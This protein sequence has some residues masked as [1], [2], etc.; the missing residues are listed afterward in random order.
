ME[1]YITRISSKKFQNYPYPIKLL[2]TGC[3]RMMNM[4]SKQVVDQT[5]IPGPYYYMRL[6][7]TLSLVPHQNT[8]TYRIS[9]FLFL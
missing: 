8:I 7:H 5:T 1:F 2:A 4:R 6:S 3:Q 9:F